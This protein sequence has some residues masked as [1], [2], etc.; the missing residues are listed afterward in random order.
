MQDGV[1]LDPMGLAFS[2][3]ETLLHGGQLLLLLLDL[4]VEQLVLILEEFYLGQQFVHL[5][6]ML[7]AGVFEGCKRDVLPRDQVLHVFRGICLFFRG[8][9]VIE[10]YFFDLGFFLLGPSPLLELLIGDDDA[11]VLL[12]RPGVLLLDL[13]N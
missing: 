6:G 2:L 10:V 11:V 4:L 8:E 5:D 13:L 1:A 7:F 12:V 3:A 9:M